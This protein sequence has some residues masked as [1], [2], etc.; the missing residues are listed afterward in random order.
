MLPGA[1][2]YDRERQLE[3]V[4]GI[5]LCKVGNVTLIIL[6][7]LNN[8]A[9]RGTKLGIL[10]NCFTEFWL[11]NSKENILRD[12]CAYKKKCIVVLDQRSYIL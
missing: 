5:F 7:R 9:V 8:S 11:S 12:G 2:T 3:L 6:A 4:T 10:G 1:N